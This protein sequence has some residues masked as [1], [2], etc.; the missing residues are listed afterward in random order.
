MSTYPTPSDP[1][2][3]QKEEN[4]GTLASWNMANMVTSLALKTL[5]LLS[6]SLCFVKN[7]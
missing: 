1:I 5:A 4:E 3:K 6:H 7:Y 2:I